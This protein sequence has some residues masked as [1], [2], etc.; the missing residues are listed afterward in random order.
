MLDRTRGAGRYELARY[1]VDRGASA[2]IFLAAA[3]GLTD[4]VRAMLQS[5]P[6]LLDE[7]TGQGAYAEQPPSSYHIYM[8][9]IGGSRSPLDTAGQF[10]QKDTLQA[11][12]PF[13]TPSQR[14]HFACR[15]DEAMARELLRENPGFVA[16]MSAD[17]HSA[18]ADAAWIG[19]ERAVTLM[20][21]LGFDP[22]V[23]G[24]DSGTA[25]HCAAW[26]GS[27]G[28]V[29]AILRHPDAHA[30]VA[31][32]DGHY[33]ATPLGWCCHGSVNGNSD[34]DHAGVA[35]LLLEKGAQ[36]GPDT[37]HASDSVEEVL[38]GWSRSR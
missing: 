18:L 17:D 15:R 6:T 11:M 31:I 30:L 13:A 14:F 23:P 27:P 25:L 35:R 22:R 1:L 20:L 7:K 8:W 32:K 10:E 38:A 16:A 33:G 19:D 26:E 5:N 36:P 28:V 21:D 37:Q 12:L 29:A 2:D 9:T 34:H 24:H 3:L 4:S